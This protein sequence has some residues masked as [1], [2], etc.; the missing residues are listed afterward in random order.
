VKRNAL[1]TQESYTFSEVQ[2]RQLLISK[3][4]EANVKAWRECVIAKMQGESLA[5]W[6]EQVT[7]L[8]AVLQIR[9]KLGLAANP[10]APVDI[11]I[12][13]AQDLHGK[14]SIHL[15]S[16]TNNYS[17]ILRRTKENGDVTGTVNGKAGHSN[18]SASLRLTTPKPP[19]SVTLSV[20][21]KAETSAELVIGPYERDATVRLVLTN[22]AVWNASG[23]P[24]FGYELRT[25][26]GAVR[27]QVGLGEGAGVQTLTKVVT[28]RLPVDQKDTVRA[29]TGNQHADAIK[30][31]LEATVIFE[32][33]LK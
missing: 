2:T 22:Q 10:L 28:Y 33:P 8:S 19:K 21:V 20:D 30:L 26:A 6:F 25:M 5:C 32:E 3:V 18:F 14:S 23:N 12:L 7:S 24:K 11:E 17:V 29:T 1:L 9:W 15:E 13:G 4:D 16:L 27:D 31:M